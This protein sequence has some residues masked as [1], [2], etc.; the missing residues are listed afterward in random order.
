L[1]ASAFESIAFSAAIIIALAYIVN[2]L[3]NLFALGSPPGALTILV[4]GL[5]LANI[6]GTWIA[7][8]WQK[9]RPPPPSPQ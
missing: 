5:L 3:L 8:A 7:A 9:K 1:A 6:R 4:A 2:I